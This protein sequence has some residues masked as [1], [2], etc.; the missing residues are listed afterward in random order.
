[1]NS[2]MYKQIRFGAKSPPHFL[3]RS[4]SVS[5]DSSSSETSSGASSL[6]WGGVASDVVEDIKSGEITRGKVVIVFDGGVVPVDGVVLASSEKLTTPILFNESGLTGETAPAA[7]FPVNIGID[8]ASCAD[9]SDWA[10]VSRSVRDRLVKL[11][12]EVSAEEPNASNVKFSGSFYPA[13]ANA[14]APDGKEIASF[15]YKNAA[16]RGSKL[17]GSSWV[18]ILAI[19]TGH[20]TK[21]GL[22]FIKGT[23]SL[24]VQRSFFSL[25]SRLQKPE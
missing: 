6:N 1:M 13:G 5:S 17:H 16:Y 8:F 9:L 2:T 3:S 10:A 7:K 14:D 11:D 19:H 18:L 21:E 15:G 4:L 23:I 12:P 25:E 22:A 20:Q 24:L